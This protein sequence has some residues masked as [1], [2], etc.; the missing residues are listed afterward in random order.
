ME[1]NKKPK[2]KRPT[3]E[4]QLKRELAASEQRNAENN[5]DFHQVKGRLTSICAV[6]ES[7][8]RVSTHI[9][10]S[11]GIKHYHTIEDSPYRS[12]TE[13]TAE[14]KLEKIQLVMIDLGR[15]FAVEDESTMLM[16]E[17]KDDLMKIIGTLT[18]DQT[19]PN[20]FAEQMALLNHNIEQAKKNGGGVQINKI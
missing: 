16:Q 15:E 9:A 13:P 12:N 7:L 1:S 11:S 18:N 5:R 4:D 14:M 19:R 8:Y 10:R 2:A 17:H 20:E 3:K 6:V